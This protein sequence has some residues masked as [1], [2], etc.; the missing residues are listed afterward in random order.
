MPAAVAVPEPY[1][2]VIVT[3]H[4]RRRYLPEALRSLEAQTLDKG[5]F[6][7]IV[8]KNFEDPTSDE[9]IRR[10]EWKNVVTDVKPLGGKIVIGVEES[11]GDVIT[12][13]EDDDMYVPERLQVVERRFREIKDLV[14][15]HNAQMVI[16]EEGNVVP[17]HIAKLLVPSGY[18]RGDLLV[19]EKV[20]RV[21]CS[22]D[23]VN[24]LAGADFNNSSIAIRAGLVDGDALRVLK[25]LPTAVDLF[26]YAR[27][28]NSDGSMYLARSKLTMYRVHLHSLS[29]HLPPWIALKQLQT[30]KLST[31]KEKIRIA[32]LPVTVARLL[33]C[34][35]VHKLA[36]TNCSPYNMYWICNLNGR[37]DW[38]R[39]SR[40]A[41]LAGRISFFELLK[42]LTISTYLTKR[43]N[44]FIFEYFKKNPENLTPEI[45]IEWKESSHIR[46]FLELYAIA[47][48]AIIKYLS[49]FLPTR[50]KD[51]YLDVSV[52]LELLGQLKKLKRELLKSRNR[53]TR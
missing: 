51:A 12:F 29:G 35:I 27:A 40:N 4:D 7:V 26:F 46:E 10:N 17:T 18:L 50:M 43:Y 23:Y 3:A 52:K 21:P 33:S 2:S 41:L 9:I 1:V 22:I 38:I 11:R 8:V 44:N 19:D 36:L 31:L 25:G 28:F 48:I 34:P 16:D 6:E 32:R 45:A 47:Y 30:S 24:I 13:L 5:K 20:K 53:N 14:Y 49:Q 42:D 15:F 37:L 39:H